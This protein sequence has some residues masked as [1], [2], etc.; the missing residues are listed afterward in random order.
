VNSLVFVEDKSFSSSQK[1]T[2]EEPDLEI[3]F[4]FKAV[5]QVYQDTP[6]Y[7]KIHHS[8]PRYT[9]VYSMKFKGVYH[10][11]LKVK[12]VYHNTPKYNR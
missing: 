11:I 9:T 4:K 8:I 1:V 12:G 5:Y 6:Q 2:M 7:T 10:K 3:L